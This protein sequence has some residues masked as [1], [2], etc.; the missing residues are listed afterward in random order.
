MILAEMVET[1]DAVIYRAR[2]QDPPG[3]QAQSREEQRKEAASWEILRRLTIEIEQ[4]A[5]RR[6]PSFPSRPEPQKTP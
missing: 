2:P 6:E 5:S 1:E 4:P 3:A